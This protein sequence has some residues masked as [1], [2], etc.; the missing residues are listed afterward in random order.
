MRL[1][2]NF[3]L[4]YL[5]L[6]IGQM[7]I[8]NFTNLG[9]YIFLSILPAMILCIPTSVS[10]ISCMCLAFASGLSV[11]W[12]AEGILGLNA[13]ALIPVA[14]A[15]K[16]L[17]RIFIGEDILANN[18]SISLRKNGLAKISYAAVSCC[19][20]FLAIYIL[21]DGA[22]QWSFS[23][24]AIRFGVSLACNWL[25]SLIIIRILTPDDRK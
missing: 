20:I 9:P 13:S 18:D 4:T 21:L 8:C 22:G 7:M 2:Q 5:L 11:D 10:T 24:S 17:I 12:L 14:L 23:F 3:S 16:G 19:A 25:L 6:L 1:P 15:R